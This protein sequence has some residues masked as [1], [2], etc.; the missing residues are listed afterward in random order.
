MDVGIIMKIVG[1]G[2]LVCVAGQVLSKSGRE[3]QAGFVTV[4]GILAVLFFL[5]SEIESLL[6]TVK[7]LFGL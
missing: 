5:V 4:A 3:E 6:S 1:V 7:G 2:L